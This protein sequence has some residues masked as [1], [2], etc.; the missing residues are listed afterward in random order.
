MSD[1]EPQEILPPV[2]KPPQYSHIKP[3]ELPEDRPP[4][5]RTRERSLKHEEKEA[6]SELTE[7]GMFLEI[8][9]KLAVA[10]ADKNKLLELWIKKEA[11]DSARRNDFELSQRQYLWFMMADKER[12]MGHIR[13]LAGAF[14][15]LADKYGEIKQQDAKS[16]VE[17]IMMVATGVLQIPIFVELQSMLVEKLKRKKPLADPRKEKMRRKLQR[18]IEALE[19][20]EEEDEPHPE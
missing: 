15:G 9:G 6:E 2:E 18:E 4:A 13:D 12:D 14:I 8:V 17:E 10:E 5:R 19:E 7:K 3:N 20:T 16:K 1:K 11:K